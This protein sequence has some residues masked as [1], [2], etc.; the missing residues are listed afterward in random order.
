MKRSGIL[1]LILLAWGQVYS[2]TCIPV[3][4]RHVNVRSGPGIQ[5]RAVASMP[6]GESTCTTNY[7]VFQYREVYRVDDMH[8]VNLYSNPPCVFGMNLG[9]LCINR[10]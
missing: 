3:A 2:E 7:Q 1:I 4:G 6:Y 10:E 8:F 5:H 9:C